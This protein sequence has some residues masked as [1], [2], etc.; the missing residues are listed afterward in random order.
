MELNGKRWSPITKSII[1]ID[2]NLLDQ[3]KPGQITGGKPHEYTQQS[4]PKAA[5]TGSI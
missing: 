4:Q 1:R 3:T 5:F 2:K